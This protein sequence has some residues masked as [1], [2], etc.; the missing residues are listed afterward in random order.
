MKIFSDLSSFRTALVAAVS[1]LALL[2]SPASA[3]NYYTAGHGDLGVAYTPGETEFEPHWHLGG[4]AIVNGSPLS[5]EEEYAPGDAIAW[6]TATFAA[7]SGAADWLGVAPGSTVFRLGT[8]S[9]PPNLGWATEEAGAETDWFDGTINISLTG[10][11]N[12]NRGEFA[13][14]SGGNALFSTYGASANSW[15]FDVEVGHAHATWYFSQAGYYELSFTWSGLYVGEGA[16]LEGIEVIGAGTFGFQAGAIPEPS[17]YAAVFGAAVLG[18]ALL[19]RR[20][21][22]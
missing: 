6:T 8:N 21:R 13:L 14:V 16:P 3:Q 12:A 7:P 17:T 11:N 5:T 22:A 19:R 2:A 9:F 18:L 15:D 10:W 1:L 4:G 20:R